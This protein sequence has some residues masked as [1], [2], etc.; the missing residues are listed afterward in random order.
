MQCNLNGDRCG[1][2]SLSLSLCSDFTAGWMDGFPALE[3][4]SMHD[5]TRKFQRHVSLEL[6]VHG[7]YAVVVLY[8]LN[9]PPLQPVTN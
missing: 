3:L 4:W 7:T 2:L 9:S 8:K 1:V 5:C 6:S